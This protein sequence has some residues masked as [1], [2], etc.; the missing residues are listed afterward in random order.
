MFASDVRMRC[1]RRHPMF[2]SFCGAKQ[3]TSTKSITG[4]F[5]PHS[6]P[7]A[8]FA[9]DVRM[10]CTRRDAMFA[11]FAKQNL[12]HSMKRLTIR[13]IFNSRSL[14]FKTRNVLQTDFIVFDLI[15]WNEI[16]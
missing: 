13:I 11:S 8:M 14:N 3:Y 4:K 15:D 7:D 6:V 5:T 1:T 16:N 9:S 12:N 2:A 10:R